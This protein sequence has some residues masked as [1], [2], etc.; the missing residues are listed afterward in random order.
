MQASSSCRTGRPV[1]GLGRRHQES[2]TLLMLLTEALLLLL[3]GCP[4]ELLAGLEPEEY[5]VSLGKL[6]TMQADF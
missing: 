5:E 3:P 4:H 2:V 1:I 6:V